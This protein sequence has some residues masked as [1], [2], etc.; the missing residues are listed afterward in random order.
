M[1]NNQDFLKGIAKIGVKIGVGLL[2]LL[3]VII[4]N[5]TVQIVNFMSSINPMLG[6]ITL[7]LLI[8][9]FAS[10]LLMPLLGF[11]RYNKGMELPEDEE[12]EE[13]KE[14]LQRTRKSLTRNKYLKQENFEFDGEKDLKE[15]ILRAY[16]ILDEKARTSI[17][18][19]STGVFLTTAISQNGVL[20]GFFVLGALTKMVWEL[21]TLYETRPS[22]NR[23][24]VLYGNV[25]ATV[26]MARGVED[27]DLLD[28][29]IEPLVASILGG[30]MATLVPGA[31]TVTTI[32]VNSITEG[33]VNALLTLRVGCI[34]QRYLSTLTKPD[35]KSL[36]RS[37]TIEALSMLGSVMKDN[38]VIILKAFSKGA[39]R[40]ARNTMKSTFKF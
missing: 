13:F 28:E 2:I 23:M 35:R 17:K 37:A 27:L 6:N 10:L 33:S 18:E 19:K 31:V 40:A 38:T 1:E 29:Q 9:L 32:V 16:G 15:E 25:A 34:T 11:L 8:V 5:Q 24:L 4:F 14:Y 7:V 3:L 36:R 30:G 26:L 20:D 21:A 39:T 22:L 12:S